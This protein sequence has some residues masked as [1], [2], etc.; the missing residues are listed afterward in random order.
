MHT[1]MVSIST[2]ARRYHCDAH[3]DGFHQYLSWGYRLETAVKT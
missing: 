3:N 2:L 1:M